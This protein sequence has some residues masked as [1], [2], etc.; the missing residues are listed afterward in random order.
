MLRLGSMKNGAMARRKNAADTL[1]QSVQN[2]ITSEMGLA[3]MDVAD[4]IRPYPEVIAHLQ[5]VEN[6]N[7]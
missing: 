4:V 7:F 6:D 1:S 3:L 2:N 5:H